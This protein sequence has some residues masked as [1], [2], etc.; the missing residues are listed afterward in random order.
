M[1]F[2]SRESYLTPR[3]ERNLFGV[4]EQIAEKKNI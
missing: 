4:L 3:D 1:Y 2:A